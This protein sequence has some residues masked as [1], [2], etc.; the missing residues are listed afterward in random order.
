M[1]FLLGFI[2]I[3]RYSVEGAQNVVIL[4]H[5]EKALKWLRKRDWGMSK[6]ICSNCYKAF[7]SD[8]CMPDWGL[9]LRCPKCPNEALDEVIRK[10]AEYD[11]KIERLDAIFI[12]EHLMKKLNG[13]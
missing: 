5:L 8:L 12:S 1:I 11:A 10:L 4:V 7:E 9:G 13:Y 2:A 3:V 6:H